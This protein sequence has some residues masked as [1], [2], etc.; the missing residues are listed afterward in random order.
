MDLFSFDLGVAAWP[1]LGLTKS[2]TGRSLKRHLRQDELDAMLELAQ[3]PAA[4]R[5]L[6]TR[7][8]LMERSFAR[9][10]RYGL[11]R[12][13]WRRLWRVRI[14][15]YLTASIQNILVLIRNIKEP[16][17]ALGKNRENAA[18]KVK[19]PLNHQ[20]FCAVKI[21]LMHLLIKLLRPKHAV[22]LC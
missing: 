19:Y 5:D 6:K 21:I 8:H 3:S 1:D 4:K 14:Q 18:N 9:G 13:R 10:S 22:I 20:Q 16:A 15:E 7:Q 17:A 11:Q 12:A 2:S